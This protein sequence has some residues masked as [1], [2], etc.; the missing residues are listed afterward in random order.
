MKKKALI[1]IISLIA[2]LVLF[3]PI[4]SGALKDGGT[5]E[6]TALTYKLVK[7]NKLIS[8]GEIYKAWRIY[9]FPLN[10]KS[11]DELW[12]KEA[13]NLTEENEKRV[14]EENTD[15]TVT[16]KKPPDTTNCK[17]FSDETEFSVSV[18]EISLTG[19]SPY[20]KIEITNHSNT[21]FCFGET[22]DIFYRKNK[23]DIRESCFKEE[24]AFNAILYTVLPGGGT[25]QT[26]LLGQADV[27]K[28]G[29]YS[30]EARGCFESDS[31]SAAAEW[32]TFGA[33][34]S[35]NGGKS[36]NIKTFSARC[37][38]DPVPHYHYPAD[39]PQTVE[40]PISGY[41]GNMVT[42]VYI[43]GKTYSLMYDKSVYITDILVNLDYDIDKVCLCI[44]EFTV[45]TELI[46]GCGI[47]L[48]QSFARCEKGQAE[49]TKEQIYG[50]KNIIDSLG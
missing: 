6:Y 48:T 20:I 23:S 31:A 33:E 3:F 28:D 1:L 9:P 25:D 49:L 7:W 41:C 35:V 27:S 39:E 47:N 37:M 5:R 32:F 24:P 19:A 46:K 40:D 30:L 21:V 10:T 26:Y 36:E 13:A 2:L 17:E 18:K 11:V 29:Y 42:T 16:E 50:I 45:D 12:Q 34:F 43:N 38:V 4:P 8:D 15:N 22:F 44:D 14:T